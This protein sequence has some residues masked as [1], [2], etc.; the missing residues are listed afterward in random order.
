MEKHEGEHH[1]ALITG[2][3][4][5][6]GRAVAR[7]LATHGASVAVV[8]SHPAGEGIVREMAGLK[9]TV[10]F[11]PADVTKEHDVKRSVD[12]TCEV[13]GPIDLL[14]N[15]AGIIGRMASLLTYSDDEFD[16][17]MAIN[18]KG[19]WLYM[20]YVIPVMPAAGGAIVN[21]SSRL[22]LVGSR[23]LALYAASKHA[24]I[25]L[26]QSAALE[27]AANNIRINAI[28]P[29]SVSTPMMTAVDAGRKRQHSEEATPIPL[30]R[31]ADADEVAQLVVFL[32]SHQASYIT[33]ASYTIDGGWSAG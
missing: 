7:L 3:V 17:L 15:N 18:F 24:V 11:I 28:C 9:G 26:T 1:V 5:G 33:G 13:L 12:E 20:K 27:F 25:G 4:G 16:Q 29:G 21:V 31:Y 32:L 23:G 10:R 8:D 14:V 30:N 6:I 19:I 22:G 2:G